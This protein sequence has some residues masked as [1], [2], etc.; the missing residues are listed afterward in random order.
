MRY[1]LKLPIACHVEVGIYEGW[2]VEVV[3]L[4][5]NEILIKNTA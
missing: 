5:P 4:L 3:G 2:I 1:F